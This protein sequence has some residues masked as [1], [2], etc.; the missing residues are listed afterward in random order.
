MVLPNEVLD[1]SFENASS[2]LTGWDEPN[3]GHLTRVVSGSATHGAAIART[4]TTA[5]GARR[6]YSPPYTAAPGDTKSVGI[7]VGGGSG[8]NTCSL[9]IRW[10]KADGTLIS[11]IKGTSAV[12]NGALTRVTYV[13][14]TAAPALTARYRIMFT[15]DAGTASRVFDLDRALATHGTYSGAWVPYT[16]GGS[17]EPL[18]L[19]VYLGRGTVA[20]TQPH[21][22]ETI[23]DDASSNLAKYMSEVE[24]RKADGV[25][26]L[27]HVVFPS[28]SPSRLEGITGRYAFETGLM[29]NEGI[30]TVYRAHALFDLHVGTEL[31]DA[32]YRTIFVGKPWNEF[33]DQDSNSANALA[34]WDEYYLSSSG[35]E[36]FGWYAAVTTNG[37]TTVTIVHETEDEDDYF[38]TKARVWLLARIA[39]HFTNHPGEPL[40]IRHCPFD[41][42]GVSGGEDPGGMEF[43]VEVIDRADADMDPA[44]DPINL[45]E[46]GNCGDPAHD[47]G[48]PLLTLPDPSDAQWLNRRPLN[49]LAWMKTTTLSSGELAICLRRHVE[50]VQAVQAANRTMIAVR[51][52]F[53]SEGQ[54]ESTLSTVGGDN[55]YHL[56]ENGL[57]KGKGSVELDHDCIVSMVIRPPG[58][59]DAR[60]VYQMTHQIDMPA[61]YLDYAGQAMPAEWSGWSLRPYV[62]GGTPDGP[63]TISP[64]AFEGPAI[65]SQTNTD[66]PPGAYALRTVDYG[67]TDYGNVN[68]TPPD[69]TTGAL[70]YRIQ[71]PWHYA[72]R[73]PTTLDVDKEALDDA[74]GAILAA[75][76][77]EDSRDACRAV[78]ELGPPGEGEGDV[79][80]DSGYVVTLMHGWTGKLIDERGLMADNVYRYH[81]SEDQVFAA[82][83]APPGV[84]WGGAAVSM[85]LKH[86][87]ANGEYDDPGSDED[88]ECSVVGTP[89]VVTVVKSE[90]VQLAVG[91]WR[92]LVTIDKGSRQTVVDAGFVVV[93]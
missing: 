44:W 70:Y 93:T 85:L 47:G 69:A 66:Q 7:D 5:T 1:G 37:G 4:S 23:I 80:I 67:Y 61:T 9:G 62:E 74:L 58:G 68:G 43:P 26:F 42:H 15:A 60:T 83:V 3:G 40:Y 20:A 19:D 72:N 86:V 81:T 10:E 45:Y 55:G 6:Y 51:E 87:D 82:V 90:V 21:I 84:G 54:W 46:F 22:F 13:A 49:A 2:A 25:E 39:A 14:A 31:Q 11:E 52:L 57:E 18:T 28:C 76:P 53:E 29:D 64:N 24:S 41:G 34:G 71:E 77:G 27:N 56:G 65:A 73:W 50:R 30:D 63:R 75:D 59:T 35:V 16:I 33:P 88:L 89:G 36:G 91:Y 38:E 78:L 17:G 79:G 8:S 32:G 48:C 12:R 92:S